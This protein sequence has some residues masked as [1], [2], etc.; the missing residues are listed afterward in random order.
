MYN[1]CWNYFLRLSGVATFENNESE[2][3]KGSVITGEFKTSFPIV[4][5]E[6]GVFGIVQSAEAV[7][8]SFKS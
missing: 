7:I 4:S 3:N 2:F 1:C 8:K 6:M 5:K